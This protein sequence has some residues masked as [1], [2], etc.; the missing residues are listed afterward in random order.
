M[1]WC[2]RRASVGLLTELRIGCCCCAPRSPWDTHGTRCRLSS[3]KHLKIN[4]INDDLGLLVTSRHTLRSDATAPLG[5][6]I[7]SSPP[8]SSPIPAPITTYPHLPGPAF[9]LQM[10][11]ISI[12]RFPPNKKNKPQGTT[13]ILVFTRQMTRELRSDQSQW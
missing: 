12:S 3:G 5:E 4:N 8:I 2:Q 13:A 7:S 9:F 10:C 1:L 6:A 11:A